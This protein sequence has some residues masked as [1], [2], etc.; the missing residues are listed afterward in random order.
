M[1][2]DVEHY[3]FITISSLMIILFTLHC[4]LTYKKYK[5]YNEYCK[6]LG[7]KYQKN[8]VGM[9][10]CLQNYLYNFNSK[11]LLNSIG[12]DYGSIISGKYKDIDFYIVECQEAERKNNKL[13]IYCSQIFL[14]SKENTT[15]PEFYEANKECQYESN[16]KSYLA[17]YKSNHIFG[18][19]DRIYLLDW[20]SKGFEARILE[21]SNKDK[22]LSE[23]KPDKQN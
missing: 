22:L 19:E 11:I 17:Y 14:L 15:L 12:K 8:S 20:I 6:A 10:E 16:G 2:L 21:Q 3:L 4:I 5:K 7:Y 18:I 1:N 9:P 13:S 23:I